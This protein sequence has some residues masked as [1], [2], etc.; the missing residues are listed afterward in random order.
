MDVIFVVLLYHDTLLVG[1][2]RDIVY[3][4]GL[5]KSNM[6]MYLNL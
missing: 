6:S 5:N 3:F 1:S 4:E 2:C